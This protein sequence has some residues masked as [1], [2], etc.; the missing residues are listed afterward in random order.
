MYSIGEMSAAPVALA[1]ISEEAVRDG[2]GPP[3]T[4]L[5]VKCVTARGGCHDTAPLRKKI[6]V[7]LCSIY[8]HEVIN[9][10]FN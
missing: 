7:M 8:K 1:V 6:S 2:S 5:K 4:E 9:H 10:F 3:I